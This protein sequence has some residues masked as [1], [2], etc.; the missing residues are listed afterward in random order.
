MASFMSLSFPY[1]S[2]AI[3]DVSHLIPNFSYNIV[4]DHP[5]YKRLITP[6]PPAVPTSHMKVMKTYFFTELVI[7]E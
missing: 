3:A 4:L 6:H 2:I 1:I 7:H 5:N